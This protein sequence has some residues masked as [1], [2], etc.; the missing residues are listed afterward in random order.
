[1]AVLLDCKINLSVLWGEIVPVCTEHKQRHTN[2]FC[3]QN[4][5]LFNIKIG[6]YVK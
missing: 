5:E 3:G 2:T 1:M 4:I 6:G